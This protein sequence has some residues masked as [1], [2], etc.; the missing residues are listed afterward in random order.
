M[1]K[2]QSSIKGEKK[3]NIG[4]KRKVFNL[5]LKNNLN[6]QFE[7]NEGGLGNE[8]KRQLE[9]FNNLQSKKPKVNIKAK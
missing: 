9:L 5:I 6:L 8:R 3:A 7:S 2:F 4:E 1:G